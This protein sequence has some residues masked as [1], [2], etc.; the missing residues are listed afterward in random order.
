MHSQTSLIASQVRLQQWIEQIQDC[1]N[2][3]KEMNVDEWCQLHGITKTNYYYRLRRVREACLDSAKIEAVPSFVEL[4]APTSQTTPVEPVPSDT[5][6]VMC[7]SN[8]IRIELHNRA[9]TEFLKNLIQA[10]HYAE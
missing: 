1:K 2:R 3:P 7:L 9:S 4:P 5:A 10:V 6:G 8:G